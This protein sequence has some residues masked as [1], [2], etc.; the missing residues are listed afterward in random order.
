MFSSATAPTY[1]ARISSTAVATSRWAAPGIT[2]TSQRSDARRSGKT[3]R[4]V[5]RK[6]SRT[7]GGT[8]TTITTPRPRRTRS[9][10]RYLML[11][12]PLSE[13][14]TQ[15]R[16]RD[17]TKPLEVGGVTGELQPGIQCEMVDEEVDHG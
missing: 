1:Y 5:T 15:R 16:K 2:S 12:K 3:R 9:G 7:S 17:A 8:G 14:E 4:R 13:S 11:E 10:S 6:R